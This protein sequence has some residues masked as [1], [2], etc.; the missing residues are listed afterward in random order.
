MFKNLWFAKA[1]SLNWKAEGEQEQ[2][3]HGNEQAEVT[4]RKEKQGHQNQ[5]PFH[6][7]GKSEVLRDLHNRDVAKRVT[8]VNKRR[9]GARISRAQEQ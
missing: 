7:E 1:S 3:E 6:P 9:P 4:P 5:H 8:P 2:T